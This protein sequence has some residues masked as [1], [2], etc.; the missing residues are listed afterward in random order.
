MS[1]PSGKTNGRKRSA[2]RTVEEGSEKGGVLHGSRHLVVEG[3]EGCEY[4]Q[5]IPSA[6]V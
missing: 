4:E 1:V 3:S 2:R 6:I 5:D